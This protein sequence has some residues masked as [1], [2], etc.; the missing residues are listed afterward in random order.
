M[1]V[2]SSCHPILSPDSCSKFFRAH[3][4]WVCLKIEPPQ[5]PWSTIIVCMKT[6]IWDNCKAPP[7]WRQIMHPHIYSWSHTHHESIIQFETHLPCCGLHIHRNSHE[8]RLFATQIYLSLS[9][10][11]V[12]KHSLIILVHSEPMINTGKKLGKT[13]GFS[14]S[15]DSVTGRATKTVASC[16][17]GLE[18]S[19]E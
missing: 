10:F 4:T 12:Q 19:R 2:N 15:P 7:T 8:H 5:I 9:I 1:R 18:F 14:S 16:R 11:G 3:E 13:R 6:V 17:T